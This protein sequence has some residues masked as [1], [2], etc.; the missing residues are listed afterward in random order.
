MYGA[1]LLFVC[2]VYTKQSMI[3][4]PAACFGALLLLRPAT[5]L[6]G[7]ATAVVIGAAVLGIL[8]WVTEGGFFRHLFLYNLNRFDVRQLLPL[9]TLF[10][11]HALYFAVALLGNRERIG[12]L[13]AALKVKGAPLRARIAGVP[14]GE[15]YVILLF[16]LG[17]TLLMLPLI[18]KSGSNANYLIEFIC[19]VSLFVGLSVK[20]AAR[21]VLHGSAVARP[22]RL[23]S[24]VLVAALVAQVWLLPTDR[25]DKISPRP[26]QAEFAALARLIHQA[27]R[28]VLSDDM[29]L[30]LRAGKD[31]LWEP[32][33]FAELSA[34]GLVDERAFVRR[35]EAR[36]FAFLVTFGGPGAP[37]FDARYNPAV[38]AA[39]LRAYPHQ[40]RIAGFLVRTPQR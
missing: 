18:A 4:A 28:P 8:S 1:A 7:I 37:E 26:D 30:V 29:V 10:S 33:I 13:A 24:L 16:Y 36:Q 12:Q 19:V 25:F 11:A 17:T 39:I 38:T 32:A 34:K 22:M 6:R 23:L 5:A 40:R 3:A 20:E 15:P 31:V 9:L 27:D 21:L 14:G 35:I 2:A